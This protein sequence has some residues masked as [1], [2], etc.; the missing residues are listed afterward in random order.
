MNRTMNLFVAI[1]VSAFLACNLYLLYSSKSVIPKTIYVSQSERMTSGEHSE[2]LAKEGLVA[3]AEVYTVYVSDDEVVDTWE[4]K[5]GDYVYPGD[6]IATLQ[7]VR[8]E[9]Q[10]A[11]WEAER[12]A[13]MSQ[14]A[15][16]L[17]LMNSLE[18]ERDSAQS[19]ST[20]NVRRSDSTREGNEDASV[21]VGWNVDVQVDVKQ[22][23]SYAQAIAAADQELADIERQLVVVETQL[24]QNPSRPALVSPVEGVVSH[25][26]RTGSTIA[27]DIYSSQKVVV[28]YATNQEWKR[29]EQ[30]DRVMLQG[31]DLG[32]A[33]VGNVL[34]VAQ[35]PANPDRWLD[36][37]QTLDPKEVKNPLA[38]Y[39]VRILAETDMESTPF[40]VNM[41]AIVLVNEAPD[42]I[43]VKD[44]WLVDKLNDQA[45]T[46]V[47]DEEGFA[48]KVEVTT[49]F[50][51]KNNAVVTQGLQVGD[52]VV[53]AE[54][55][56]KY[57]GE[58]RIFLP[59][60]SDF[61]TKSEWKAFGWRNYVESMILK[62]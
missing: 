24:A 8:A 38:Y 3:P 13:L 22:D 49:P 18:S 1:A 51:W 54:P 40:G 53:S 48:A 6:E 20:S 31:G 52:V 4:V 35:T 55:L 46:W 42:S 43:A 34:S 60:P 57:K 5:E 21:E 16:V 12:E 29:I 50:S 11:V 47:I 37:Y 61:P 19:D 14:K 45:A 33:V 36:A 32:T 44:R 17:S 26:I 62:R 9:G 23:G 10:R 25:V 56:R 28:T 58:P 27:V 59:M 7:T 15:A 2:K 39:E 30:G 41:N